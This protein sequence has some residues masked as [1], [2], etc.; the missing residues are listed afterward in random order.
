MAKFSKGDKVESV[1]TGAK[2]VVDEVYGDEKYAVLFDGATNPDRV[3]GFQIKAANGCARNAKFK[4]GDNVKAKDGKVYTIGIVFGDAEKEPAYECLRPGAA[5]SMFSESELTLANSRSVCSANAVVQNAIS[6]RRARNADGD[7]A[8]IKKA[9]DE[10]G[11][12]E[13]IATGKVRAALKELEAQYRALALKY[14]PMVKDAAKR[15]S[16]HIWLGEYDTA[17]IIGDAMA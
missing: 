5:S 11:R 2:G 6:A 13:K 16:L 12:L 3:E 10:A 4:E 17:S 1:K 8:I 14:E 9:Q 15:N 7:D